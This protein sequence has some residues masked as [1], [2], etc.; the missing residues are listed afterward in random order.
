M[1]DIGAQVAP[2]IFLNQ[3]L[4]G[5]FSEQP[6]MAKKRS[7]FQNFQYTR[8]LTSGYNW[9]PKAWDWNS[10]NFVAKP[11]E[12]N[13]LHMGSVPSIQSEP[14][15]ENG[16]ESQGVSVLSKGNQRPV[17]ED[18]ESLKLQLG[19]G[20]NLS[21]EPVRPNKKVRSGSPGS[22][23]GNYPMCQVDDCREDLSNA[24][25]YHRR[26]KVCEVHSKATNALV[27]KQM[28]RFCQQCSRFHPLSEFDEGKRSC[29]RRLAGH[30]RR[31]RKTQPEDASSHTLIPTNHDNTGK[32]DLDI[33]NFLTV[34]ARI[35]GNKGLEISK[36]SP[37]PNKD[38]LVQILSKMNPA[39]VPAAGEGQLSGSGS[40]SR[41]LP[42]HLSPDNLSTL[43]SGIPSPPTKDLLSVLSF[44]PTSSN[45]DK[46]KLALNLNVQD[47]VPLE[48]PSAGGESTTSYQSPGEDSDSQVQEIGSKLPFQLFSSSPEDDSRP[49][50]AGAR[51]YFSSD[52]SNPIEEMSPSSSPLVQKLFPMETTRE[53]EMERVSSFREVK[54]NV[55]A[56]MTSGCVGSL[57][58]F[59]GSYKVAKSGS[60][61]TLPYQAGS[62]SSSGSDH[63]PSS[64]SSDALD[65]TGRIVFK[66][67]G[68]DP[69]H[70]PETLRSQI[71]SW[72]CRSPSEMESYIRPGCVVLTIYLS[73]PSSYWE[74]VE[75]NLMKYA[76]FLIRDP[77]TD[78]WR[79]GKFLVQVGRQ[80]VSYSDGKLRLCKSWS[81]PEVISVSPLA[82][83]AGQEATLLL[84]GH[85]LNIPG[86][87]IHCMNGGYLSEV[88]VAREEPEYDEI[89]LLGFKTQETNLGV[90]GRC[91]IEV[92]NGFRG[93][94]FPVLIA[95]ATICQEVRL[96]E[97]EFVAAKINGT[98]GENQIHDLGRPRSQE[99]ILHF[100]N[101]LGWL[102][103]RTRNYAVDIPDFRLYRF[104]FLLIFSIERD[105]CAL[106]RTLLDILL[107]KKLDGGEPSRESIEML[108]DIHL[109]N[110][111]VKRR[112]RKMVDL[113]IHYSVLSGNYARTYI[114]PP[115]LVGPGGITPLHLAASM[116]G[117]DDIIDALT[118]D[119]QEI[120]LQ[121]WN[122]L[123]DANRLSP[124]AYALMRSNHSYNTLVARK[125]ADKKNSQVSVIMRNEAEQQE[126]VWFRQGQSASCSKCAAIAGYS[127]SSTRSKGLLHHG[128]SMLSILAIAAV[129]VCVCLLLRGNPV[130]S[131]DGPFKWENVGFGSI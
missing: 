4:G 65:R 31:R 118:N 70:L 108:S 68:K 48:F 122:S 97:S 20:L 85:D 51:K 2:A 62:T 41:T 102:F 117:S 93:T 56:S 23:G 28:Q 106:V 33:V 27:G 21:D 45:P 11:L 18:D 43:K 110:R 131:Q 109:L 87:R 37:A 46:A 53:V 64:L 115:N 40:L 38:Q 35:Q 58:L 17:V 90:L 29:R 71:Y 78:F 22:G 19:G 111:S 116:S 95:D 79:G 99:E 7:L 24:K 50:L 104:K 114:F 34:L 44:T 126:N 74:Q 100:L 91:F 69:S 42:G 55:E 12:S 98:I 121:C 103:Q 94:S 84:R 26:H 39:P 123:L 124:H 73:M 112:C 66:L 52:S 120:G 82:V 107:L 15:R 127:W 63:S 9:N 92:E 57:E 5:R 125:F 86:T 77:D 13:G 3:T 30:N 6:T 83:V 89:S 81:A 14:L 76:N 72:L 119:P 25:D 67:F 96:L 75:Q 61:R 32:G 105:C 130:V 113:L 16:R 88:R 1:E 128:P 54:A 10:G 80:V 47:G 129:C 8:Q 36:S 59:G 49:K 60:G 101:E